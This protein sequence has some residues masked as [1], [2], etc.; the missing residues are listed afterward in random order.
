MVNIMKRFLCIL[1]AAIAVGMS[2]L[3]AA[4]QPPQNDQVFASMGG[5]AG[6]RKVVD[7]FL[8][9]AVRNPRIKESFED[10]DMEHLAAMLTDQFCML[11]GGPCRYEGKEMKEIH[12]DL[13]LTNAHFNALTEDL[14]EAMIRNG[15][16]YAA[17]YA[18]IAK[19]APMQRD[20][21][22]R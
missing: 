10:V 4:Q 8:S 5:K 1:V 2:P 9:I 12:E 11:T 17:Q 18:L 21:V 19:L 16:P 6:I 15:V 13:K 22:T 14:Q 20:V 3:G 7:D